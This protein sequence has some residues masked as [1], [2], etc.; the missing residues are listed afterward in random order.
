MEE[1]RILEIKNI[2]KTYGEGESK[3]EALKNISLN[4]LEGEFLVILGSSGS[5]KSTL[6]NIIGGISKPDSGEVIVNN[7]DISKSNDKELTNYRKDNIGFV[8]QTFNLL[9]ELTVEENIAITANE[10]KYPN[11]VDESLQ[12]VGLLDKKNKYVK[13]LSCGQQQ[14]VSI[15]RA[16]AKK[17]QILLC[18]EP[19]GALDYQT[20]KQILEEI[21]KI[22]RNEKKTVI[23]VT[24]TREIGK[25]ADRVITLKSGE[26]IESIINKNPVTANQIE[27]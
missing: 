5:G 2:S 8:F 20:G 27:W 3:V 19:T 7:V 12:K 13:Q 25:M 9:N 4:V 18:D 11:I 23:L 10:K 17:P 16:I 6:L 24:H 22:V 21:E 1:K 14:R 26:I 15:A